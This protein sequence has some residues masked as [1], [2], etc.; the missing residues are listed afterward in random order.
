M[1]LPRAVKKHQEELDEI[2]RR[3]QAPA[4]PNAT[5]EDGQT[6]SADGSEGETADT[7]EAPR[8][9]PGSGNDAAPTDAGSDPAADDDDGESK[10]EH[11]YRR[12]QG[13]YDAEVPRLHGEIRELKQ[14]V[15]Q[16]QAES[17][18]AAQAQQ[19]KESAA[20]QESAPKDRLVTDKDV[21]AFGDD[22][23]DLQ[24]R[25]AQ[26]VSGEFDAKLSRLRE[27]NESLRKQVTQ[28]EGVSFESRLNQTIP[29]FQ[30]IN[31]DERWVQWLDEFDP[32]IQGPRRSVAQS[33]YAR[34]DVDAV[35]A[36]VDLFK[37]TITE[38]E[39]SQSSA[40][41]PEVKPE[42]QAELQRQVQ[43]SKSSAPTGTTQPGGR[44]LSSQDF[45]RGMSR[46]AKMMQQGKYD[47]AAALESEMS[48]A[49]S[50]GRITA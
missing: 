47:E 9:E 38:P 19:A 6:G 2:E 4:D 7:G 21:E 36:Y 16:V 30:Q 26:E 11:K 35:K 27:E 5:G 37:Q 20:E 3:L 29:D 49:L 32:L 40:R 41:K 13:K 48:A 39:P 22:L 12:L 15:Q 42:R 43:P 46:A 25:V 23:I 33:A 17:A 24:R 1:T 14:R 45:E 44:M 31:N 8:D 50:E 34:G 28:V 10:W 18:Q